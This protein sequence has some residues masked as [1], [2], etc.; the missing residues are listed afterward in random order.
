[1]RP[2]PIVLRLGACEWHV[3]P[4][5]LKQIQEIEPLLLSADQGAGHSIAAAI[6]II[7]VALMR[8]HPEA[9]EKLS[10][11]EATTQEIGAAMSDVLRLGGFITAESSLEQQPGKVVAGAERTSV[12]STPA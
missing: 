4:L 12:S 11:M 7:A 10:D 5:N 8:D 6:R 2:Q 1:M 3:R 9:A